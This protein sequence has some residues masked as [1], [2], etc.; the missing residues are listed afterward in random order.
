MA[1][2]DEGNVIQSFADKYYTNVV[3]TIKYLTAVQ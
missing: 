2:S 3:K 1:C